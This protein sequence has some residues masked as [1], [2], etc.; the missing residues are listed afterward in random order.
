MIKGDESKI[1][2]VASSSLPISVFDSLLFYHI[3]YDS[4]STESSLA[5]SNQHNSFNLFHWE[6]DCL[7]PHTS[8]ISTIWVESS[9]I[10]N[11]CCPLHVPTINWKHLSFITSV[12]FHFRCPYC[13]LPPPASLATLFFIYV[14]IC[15]GTACCTN[16]SMPLP[17]QASAA[18]LCCNNLVKDVPISCSNSL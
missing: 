13:E 14:H 17:P 12:L 3:K 7:L 6:L 4:H 5:Y 1:S 11:S 8:R 15:S 9:F 18:L 16:W 10:S 2:F